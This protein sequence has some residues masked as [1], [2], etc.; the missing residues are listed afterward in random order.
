MKSF[1]DKVAVITGAGSGIGRE[2]ALQLGAAGAHL[3]LCDLNEEGL[4]ETSRQ[5]EK[6]GRYVSRH[7]VDVSNRE[8]VY[9]F[10]G[11]VIDAHGQVDI[12]INNAG[13]TLTPTFFDEI[14]D[15][16]FDKVLD[17]NMWGVYNGI[18]AFLP[19]LRQRPEANI[20]NISSAAGLL[21]MMGYSPY[22]MSKFAIRGLSETLQMELIGTNIHVT[23]VHPG[24]VKTNLLHNAPDLTNDE[25]RSAVSDLFSKGALLTP[26]KAAAG[27]IKGIRKNKNKVVMG[28]DTRVMSFVRWLFPANFPRVLHPAL[29]Y[30]MGMSAAGSETE[31]GRNIKSKT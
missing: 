31:N 14:S 3:A 7:I 30:V 8:R 4:A 27:I 29:K 16:Q 19:Y 11:E 28:P 5:P 15:A 17:V 23:S 2:L 13:I 9:Q 20:A 12:L 25:Q 18:R 1:V 24:G 21:G 10:A 26:E 6:L 22:V